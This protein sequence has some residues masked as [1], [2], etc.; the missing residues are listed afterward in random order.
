MRIAILGFGREGQSLF[1]FLRTHPRYRHAEIW[2]LDKN[3]HA[4]IPREIPRRL[5]ERYLE[6]LSAFDLVFR[7]P[8]VP[9]MTR[10]LARARKAGVRFSSPTQ[11][12][13]E[14]A[15]LR[16]A[17]IIGITGT[18][19]KGTTSTLTYRILEKAGKKV[20]LA[21]N[22]GVPAL[23]IVPKL[24]RASLVVLE[25]SSFQLIDLKESP[26]IAVVLMVT[27]EHLD[28]HMNL[29]EYAAAK[30][31]ILRFQSPRD[32]AVIAEEYPRSKSLALRAPG[33]VFTFSKKKKVERGAWVERGAFW[34]SD[35]KRAQ[36][37]CPVSDL[38]IP[39][40][41]NL[42]NTCAAIA[43]AKI[44]G[45]GVS[46]IRSAIRGFRGLEHRLELVKK[47]RGVTYYDDSYATTPETAAVAIQAFENPKV[48]ILGGS[49]KGSD[50]RRLGKT[51]SASKSVKAIIGI[52]VEWPR[53]R[54][55]IKYPAYTNATAGKQVA[56][57]KII[58]GC[59]NMREIVRAAAAAA[60]PGDVVLLSPA[61]AS[62]GMFK[63]YTDRGEQ[64]RKQ[65][66]SL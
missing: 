52:G 61:C 29:R 14:E 4:K 65:V 42:D 41:H 32:Y 38:W 54:A 64:F 9:Y 26:L 22:I 49:G 7:S 43:V 12:F 33:T 31:N 3:E 37:I 55:S 62:F 21:G 34:F 24:D 57:I 25:L 13:F 39:G 58:E 59:R 30:K 28:W 51:I 17:K 6:G 56:S 48:V 11:L 60:A 53:I 8:G 1:S 16:G 35:G 40:F 63:N 5:G 23:D 44:L 50:F 36:K 10:E 66:R 45:I 27:S 2:V 19:G 15:A 46:T 18:K 20:F 47:V